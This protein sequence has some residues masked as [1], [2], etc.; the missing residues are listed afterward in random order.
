MRLYQYTRTYR[1]DDEEREVEVDNKVVFL[2]GFSDGGERTQGFHAFEELDAF[3]AET[4]RALLADGFVLTRTHPTQSPTYAREQ[5]EAD[6]HA[7]GRAMEIPEED[8]ARV[9]HRVPR[10]EHGVLYLRALLRA[11]DGARDAL[12]GRGGDL[13]TICFGG[14]DDELGSYAREFPVV[15]A[16]GVVIGVAGLD[17]WVDLDG[18]ICRVYPFGEDGGTGFGESTNLGDVQ[19]Y[20]AQQIRVAIRDGRE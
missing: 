19:E 14:S 9:L 18:T 2:R 16:G 3:V 15:V 11:T 13:W 10:C 7:L 17:A 20:M 1:R 4:D 5:A 12:L 6:F 8:L